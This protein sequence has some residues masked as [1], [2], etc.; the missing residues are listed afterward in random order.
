VLTSKITIIPDDGTPIEA[1]ASIEGDKPLSEMDVRHTGKI[2]SDLSAGDQVALK[3]AK[4][5][6]MY[7]EGVQRVY[8]AIIDPDSW[9]F[10]AF[11]E[12]E[13]GI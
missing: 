6:Q 3:S 10:K 9:T 7:F 8:G 12:S 1:T 5:T 11:D 2:T 13:R 4:K